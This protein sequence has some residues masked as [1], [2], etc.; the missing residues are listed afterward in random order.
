MLRVL[1]ISRLDIYLIHPRLDEA[2]TGLNS[3]LPASPAAVQSGR[4]K[5]PSS[6]A[7]TADEAE[8]ARQPVGW[9]IMSGPQA[10]MTRA[11]LWCG[12][13]MR[14]P[15][16]W[17]FG[18]E[19]DTRSARLRARMR[20]CE[21]E[22][23]LWWWALECS[24][25]TRAREKP[26]PG[27]GPPPLRSPDWPD[28]L[29]DLAPADQE[30]VDMDNENS[31]WAMEVAERTHQDGAANVFENPRN[32]YLWARR[33][34]KQT[35]QAMDA[36]YSDYDACCHE[37][38]RR[39]R[40]RLMH[41]QSVHEL[42]A[43]VPA[44]CAHVHSHDEWKVTTYRDDNGN[45]R[46]YYPT[47]EE[48]AYTAGL[49]LR[50]A[51]A[52]SWW[53]VRSG[54]AKLR[55]P[56][57]PRPQC[58]GD[59]VSWLQLP[60]AALRE[61]ALPARAIALGLRPDWLELQ[62][63][64][65]L[66]HAKDK[67]NHPSGGHVVYIGPGFPAQKRP[68][69]EWA[70]PDD[71]GPDGSR[72]WCLF[73]YSCH[74]HQRMWSQL[75]HLRGAVL[76]CDCRSPSRCHGEV[77]CG[78]FYSYVQGQRAEP[79]EPRKVESRSERRVV[80]PPGERRGPHA[81]ARGSSVQ[82]LS[83]RQVTFM[84]SMGAAMSPQP[85]DAFRTSL[86][87][88]QDSLDCA[89]RSLCR[90][91]IGASLHMPILEDI[92]N[93]PPFTDYAA[94]CEERGLD[95]HSQQVPV[96]Y[97]RWERRAAQTWTGLQTAAFNSSGALRQ[98]VPFGLSK[99]EHFDASCQ[100]AS[101]P[102]PLET[103][104]AQDSDLIFAAA[105]MAKHRPHMREA[106]EYLVESLEC[107]SA[108]LQPLTVQLHSLCAQS[109][110]HISGSMHLALLLILVI[111]MRWRDVSL[112]ADYCFGHK[113]VGNIWPYDVFGQSGEPFI[114]ESR[115][116]SESWE[117]AC[118]LLKRLQPTEDDELILEK[119]QLDVDK[120]FAEPIRSYQDFREHHGPGTFRLIRRFVVTQASGKKRPCD[121]GDGGGHT[122]LT[123]DANYLQLC[124]PLQPARH[125]QAVQDELQLVG[126]NLTDGP[127]YAMETGGEDWP[128]AYRWT[129]NQPSQRLLFVVLFW[130]PVWKCPAVC[131][132]RGLLFGLKGAV[133]AFNRLSRFV[134]AAGRRLMWALVSLY[135][136]DATI[137]DWA[138]G[139]GSAQWAVSRLV[140]MLGR[141]WAPE[142]KQK[143]S[144]SGDFLGLTHDLA[145]VHVTGQ[146]TFWPREPLLSKL[147]AILVDAWLG[148]YFPPG[149]ASKVFGMWNFLESGMYGHIGR[150]G[151][152][153][154][155]DRV[156]AGTGPYDVNAGLEVLF[157][158][159]ACF[160]RWQP[161]REISIVR[162]AVN[163]FL[164]A[165]DAAADD[166]PS[167]GF[168][169]C[170]DG[171]RFGAVTQVATDALHLVLSPGEQKIA[172]YELLQV[173]YAV[174]AYPDR[175][176]NR[177][178]YWF[179]DNISALMCLV[180]GKSGVPDMDAITLIIHI[181]LCQL[182]CSVYFEYV[183]SDANWADGI[184]RDGFRDSW[185][186]EHKFVPASISLPVEIFRLD[187][188][189]LF[190][191]LSFL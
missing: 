97:S 169:V 186:A 94:W 48:A 181:T 85:S 178:G 58:T 16:D 45:S 162:K 119:T 43:F 77:L 92:L 139:R 78:C 125:T 156:Y 112:P 96:T 110:I 128:D 140:S 14:Q 83:R 44:I 184:S 42:S 29:S 118:A 150:A 188:V 5:R 35:F 104:A 141:P 2:Q 67:P 176:R 95:H 12:W 171:I 98:V 180:K 108:R 80:A 32:S 75:E 148:N 47:K 163:R 154:L 53:A 157:K 175:F 161:R 52:L 24:T 170:M 185:H 144:S 134:E 40:Q 114:D 76:W 151:L 71:P 106:R 34:T 61:Q 117:H 120:G 51:L 27:G 22:V 18:D 65:R 9:E 49:A 135:F 89:V 155:K 173:L 116:L 57:V 191:V 160:L 19:L 100:V 131:I 59:R 39:K 70:M 164:A 167:G 142:K 124:G 17:C 101:L 123:A 189:S 133:I 165:S 111:V 50:A 25:M 37:G 126:E 166:V 30:R 81:P 73:R 183:E 190:H 20:D 66:V 63:L 38:A 182:R 74:L 87:W 6:A 145:Q 137:Q 79:A 8:D 147:N 159:M 129:P 23:D 177:Y 86:R 68:P 56:S 174:L 149:M 7:D 172:Q 102:T 153:A 15:I 90:V 152:P 33:S 109:T 91:P 55:L 121:D 10:I 107:L 179:I 103:R 168:L 82:L 187:S 26:L 136:D 3:P 4:G 11:L 122:E 105:M 36:T 113:A 84:A 21:S 1:I 13:A 62:D 127:Q 69:S 143:M 132:Y 93:A 130:H 54:R 115:L 31:D 158:L 99:D 46:R 88:P 41:G 64:P 138:S 146:V 28:G 60:P 72:D